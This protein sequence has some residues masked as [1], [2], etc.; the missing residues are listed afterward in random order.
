MIDISGRAVRAGIRS[1]TAVAAVSSFAVIP[2]ITNAASAHTG[3]KPAHAHDRGTPHRDHDGREGHD[4]G[5]AEVVVDTKGPRGAIV[6]GRTYKWPFEVTNKGTVPAK[7]VALRA[8]PD[9]SLKVLSAPPKC[10][11]RRTGPLVCKIGLLPQGQTRRGVITAEVTPRAHSGKALNNPVQVS[12]RNAPAPERRMAAFPPA[13][14]SPDPT[15]PQA[16]G[17]DGRMPYPVMVT[18]HGPVTAESVVVR[19][20][21]GAPAPA[22][23]CGA[24]APA[25]A[26]DATSS[27]GP[28]AAKQ[29]DPAA[30]GCGAAAHERPAADLPPTENAVIPGRPSR[31]DRPAAVITEAPA[32]APCGATP[33]RPVVIPDRPLVPPCAGGRPVAPPPAAADHPAADHA[34]ADHPAAAPCGVTAARPV[35]IPDRPLTPP[36]AGAPDRPVTVPDRPAAAPP[37]SV[38]AHRPAAEPAGKPAGKPADEPVLGRPSVSRPSLDTP[39]IHRPEADVPAGG[40][41]AAAPCGAT[42]DRPVI[43]PD[44]PAGS[45]AGLPQRPVAAPCGAAPDRPVILPAPNPP[46]ATP[47]CAGVRGRPA[48]AEN[49][50]RPDAAPCGA[51]AVRPAR[52]VAVPDVPS[53]APCA[54]GSP[55]ACGC[56]N[57]E[58]APT[59]PAAEAAV[60]AVPG[61]PGDSGVAPCAA[62][63]KPMAGKAATERPLGPACGAPHGVPAAVHEEPATRPETVEPMTPL[64]GPG[65][66]AHPLGRPHHHG[67]RGPGR[68]HR[69][70]FRQG[71]GF[72]CPLGSAPHHRPHV[73]NLGSHPHALHCVGAAGAACHTRAARPVEVPQRPAGRLPTTGGPSGL[74]ALSGLGLAGAGVVLY[75]LSRGRRRRDGGE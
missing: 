48:A 8:T 1:I 23:P 33:A 62:E 18:E 36:C 10:R 73:I 29:D 55:G 50:D 14:V 68:P 7:D 13:E 35:V 38:P 15:G 63:D 26:D 71:T 65:K 75:G 54:Q 11:W 66:S 3:G 27:P 67:P 30:C 16:A 74:L 53:F 17:T 69:D 47:S 22:G 72:V 52:P 44:Q 40:R 5:R 12:W 59:V 9:R 46:A 57:A 19:S 25:A 70:C 4:H 2:Q 49:A 37:S 56:L 39:V 31:D 20:P 61:T 45:C 58:N 34:T 60:P 42:D 24:G 28:C 64:T 51:A 41:P 32:V 6:P 43:V 21:I